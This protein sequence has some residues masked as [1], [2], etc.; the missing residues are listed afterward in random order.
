MGDNEWVRLCDDTEDTWAAEFYCDPEQDYV[1]VCQR[2][3]EI[4]FGY[5]DLNTLAAHAP[6]VKALVDAARAA[7]EQ[8]RHDY[9]NTATAQA[10]AAGLGCDEWEAFMPVAWHSI[11][12]ALAA[13]GA[14]DDPDRPLE[15]DEFQCG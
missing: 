6:A 3:D 15:D 12:R 13:L 5:A 2:E 10:I 8:L 4:T 11:S 14:D 7:R 9:E 1:T